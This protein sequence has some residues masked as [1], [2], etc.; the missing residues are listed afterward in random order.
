MEGVV[1]KAEELIRK[2]A[3]GRTNR[4]GRPHPSTLN[5][6]TNL[7][8]VLASQAN[9]FDE[10]ETLAREVLSL[11]QKKLGEYHTSTLVSVVNLMRILLEGRDTY[12]RAYGSEIKELQAKLGEALDKGV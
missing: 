3:E 10:G 4:L 12:G 9:K 11:R 7:S 1:S 2:A 6:L 5:A 8:M